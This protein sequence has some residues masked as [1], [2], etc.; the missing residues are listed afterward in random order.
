MA[1][2]HQQ[3]VDTIDG[4]DTLARG[5]DA[6]EQLLFESRWGF[7]LEAVGAGEDSLISSLASR[8]C[9]RIPNK[10]QQKT[11]EDLL[12]PTILFEDTSQL[13]CRGA[14]KAAGNNATMTGRKMSGGGECQH[15]CVCGDFLSSTVL[16]DA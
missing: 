12:F 9:L 8:R 1:D 10:G 15:C 2:I 13:L 4:D 7:S 5:D 11:F 6:L 3:L 14:G 16:I